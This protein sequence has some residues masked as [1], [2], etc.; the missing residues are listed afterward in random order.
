VTDLGLDNQSQSSRWQLTVDDLAALLEPP[1]WHR[2][3]LCREF[4]ELSWFPGRADD[5]RPAK[6]VCGRCLVAP[7]CRSWA[8]QQGPDLQGI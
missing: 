1:S 4:P 5:V 8:L 6:A 2:D 3:A 7:E